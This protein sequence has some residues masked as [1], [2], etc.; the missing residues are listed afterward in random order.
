MR[1]TLLGPVAAAAG[2]RELT[3]G[4]L[5]QRAVFALLAL[6]AGRVVPLDRLVDELWADE[7]PSRAT[8]SLQSYVARLRHVLAAVSAQEAEAPRIV[9]RPPGWLLTL[10]PEQVDVTRFVN[11][12][13]SARRTL[14]IG[15]ADGAT[16]ATEF[17]E[18]AM[19]MW[20]GEPLAGLE[21][22]RFARQEAA[23]LNELRLDAIELLLQAHLALGET[24]SVAER[25]GQFVTAHPFRERGWCALM[26]ALY[27]CGRQSEALAAAARLRR[28]L[29]TELGVDPSPEVRRLEEQ[30]LRQDPTLSS[31]AAGLTGLPG[32][33]PATDAPASPAVTPPERARAPDADARTPL[34]GRD[35]VLSVLDAAV[36]QAK[37][38]HGRLL[39][40]H[41]PAGLGK[42]SI[43]EALEE[44]VVS[45][46][47]AV[48]RG[49]CVG[50]GAA[51]ALWPW[52]S[53]VRGIAEL[54]DSSPGSHTD[55]DQS[56][57][58]IAA[59]SALLVLQANV[60][61]GAPAP[62][63]VPT[64]DPALSRMR[65]FRGVIEA[66]AAARAAQP[67][68]VV[69]DD[70]H[71]ADKDT[72][73]LL[74]LAV[75]ELV[76]RGVLFAIS[77]R[78][79][80]PNTD[81][82][83]SLVDRLRRSAVRRVNLPPLGTPEVAVLVRAISGSDA[84]SDVIATIR[85]RTAGNPLFVCELVRL[86]SSE[87][88]LDTDGVRE[89]LPREVHEV[90]RR[91]LDRLPQ[92]TVALL[93]VVA[94]AGGPADVDQL[95][96]V[97]GLDPDAV[98]D[99]CEAAVLAG[100]LLDDTQHP[101][102]FVLSHDLVRQTLEQ[103]LSTARRLRLHARIAAVLQKHEPMTSLQIVD[104]ARHLTIAAPVVGPAAAV[105]YLMAASDDALSRYA[106]DQ[107]EQHLRTA[108]ALISQV[109]N[110][111]ERSAL[112]APVRGRLTFLLLTVRGAQA[113]EPATQEQ[114]V[115]QPRDA[116]STI[117]WLGS[118]IR[119]T[120]TGQAPEAA[121]AAEVI[122][123]SEALPEARFCA[124]FVRG[125]ASHIMGRIAVAREAFDEMEGLAA[126]GVDVQIPGFFDGA[127]V[128]ATESALLAHVGGDERRADSLMATAATRAA[129]SE[130]GLVTLAQ[131]QLWLAAMRGD[132]ELARQHSA[133]CRALADRLDVPLYGQVADLVGGWAD[134]MLG[135]PSGA[136]RA[137]TAFDQYLATGL[138]LNIPL[139]LLLRAEAHLSAGRNRQA[140]ELIRQS[141][142]LAVDRREVCLSPRLLAWAATQLPE[143]G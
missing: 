58:Q 42:S 71:W 101:G 98:L 61:L 119:A 55:G 54:I 118:M 138:R 131:H 24:D 15:G 20:T 137:D 35:D 72:L 104:V 81:T 113:E 135:D 94:V 47:G 14:A 91:R 84:N 93:T 112:E 64:G 56:E 134:A 29:A 85:S 1:V 68:A 100:L 63:A 74:S 10:D 40:L 102:S 21:A 105:P 66:I 141:R 50:A 18:Q 6:N 65:L 36:A 69:M 80:E 70:M 126:Q 114:D 124:H 116:E 143:A 53:V 19:E 130:Q 140:G 37:T 117:G 111:T 23:R 127:V 73:T 67:L 133:T 107:A 89:T 3:L 45:D 125:F 83:L 103:S 75:D 59:R 96:N 34:V 31:S 77:V 115:I 13:S 11:L 62:D 78:A 97:T 106:N 90:L 86:L 120:L 88:R 76:D 32:E 16:T 49:D 5:K 51:P 95:A 121:A 60:S 38:G 52:V 57:E 122:L 123:A 12:V 136:D 30:I 7:P 108:L 4:G 92:Q 28:T 109:Q 8:L 79:D 39:V 142:A 22:V 17:L 2:G 48:L 128:A 110:P 46:G 43:L 9:T 44:R 129:G 82:V 33:S 25:A 41:A 132:P 26:L 27:R 87:R 99:G 139:Y